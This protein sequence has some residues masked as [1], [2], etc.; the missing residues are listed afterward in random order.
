M[1]L[2]NRLLSH[3]TYRAA[4]SSTEEISDYEKQRLE[5]IRRN[6][7]V[8]DQLGIEQDKVPPKTKR[9]YKKRDKNAQPTR[10]STRKRNTTSYD[11]DD[12]D[13]D[14]KTKK[15]KKLKKSQRTPPKSVAQRMTRNNKM[16]ETATFGANYVGCSKPARIRHMI[17]TTD[18]YEKV[19]PAILKEVLEHN[20]GILP[21]ENGKYKFVS[22]HKLKKTSHYLATFGNGDY[23]T[24]C[25]P[26]LAAVVAHY[27][28]LHPELTREQVW[29]IIGIRDMK[30][31]PDLVAQ[32]KERLSETEKQEANEARQEN[33]AMSL[34]ES[35][36]NEQQEALDEQQE[37]LDEQQE[38]LD[39]Q[40][41]ALDEQQE[42]E[43]DEEEFDEQQEQD[44][45]GDEAFGEEA[46]GEEALDEQQEEFDEQQGE[47]ET[48]GDLRSWCSICSSM[49]DDVHGEPIK[50][51]VGCTLCSNWVCM[52]HVKSKPSSYICPSCR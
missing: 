16:H 41:E 4:G 26:R 40:Q 37:E 19:P 11:E 29:E 27:G 30:A 52:E 6:K 20:K 21:Q 2:I 17:S 9:M 5:N 36:L 51:S 50:D 14:R 12:D 7:A 23:G 24:F 1:D 25:D 46:F 18:S 32:Y 38:A 34:I 10:S 8:L 31:C 28:K 22:Y 3:V 48:T 45:F 15:T 43:F 49:I 13:Y 35:L 44:A 33:E 47:E 39:E 42:Q